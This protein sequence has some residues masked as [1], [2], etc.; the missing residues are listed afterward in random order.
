MVTIDTSTNFDT[1]D[2]KLS[3]YG[4]HA[5]FLY[6]HQLKDIESLIPLMPII[7]LYEHH[8]PMGHWVSIFVN[9]EG[10][11]Y[12]DSTS[13]TPD[14]LLGKEIFDN[15]KGRDATGS[16][17][18]YLNQLLLNAIEA[19]DTKL[20]YN[21]HKLQKQGTATCGP[22]NVIRL[23]FGEFTNKQF[24]SLFKSIRLGERDKKVVKLFNAL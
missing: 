17:F 11:N 18:T 19:L 6:Y 3:T 9:S 2:Q 23:L 13:H 10:L 8:Y 7:L 22:W 24:H 15:P 12:F 21:E 20:I 14:F 1:L 4:I 5:T 16:D